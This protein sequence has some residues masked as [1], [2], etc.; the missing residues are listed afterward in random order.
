MAIRKK[1]DWAL[2]DS[3]AT[4]ENKFNDRRRLLKAM[5]VGSI[6]LAAPTVARWGEP[7]VAPP[8]P[9]APELAAEQAALYPVAR[10]P[11]Y[12]IERPLTDEE[13][14]TTYNNFYHFGSHKRI[15]RAAQALPISPW[16]VTIDGM[17]EKPITIDAHDLIKRMPLEERLYRH[18]CVEA[19]A[20][21]VPWSGFPLSALVSLAKPLSSARYLRME[22]FND[23]AVASGQKAAW[24]PWPYVEG[25]SLAEATN[26]LVFIATGIY[27]KPLPPQNGAPLRLVAPWKYGFKSIKSIKRITFTD[28][29]PV[30]FWEEL[31]VREYGFWANVNPA[32][33]HPRWSQARERVL[34]TDETIPTVLFNGYGAEVAHLYDGLEA[35]FG[36]RVWR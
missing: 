6:I 20:M 21:T 13:Y 9:V 2:P 15:W 30:S 19:W 31:A 5:A 18:R 27:G 35:E 34:G 36:D 8:P 12:T 28:V 17:V 1:P 33:D 25:L 7:S 16:Q 26:E 10:N 4:P 32:V 24:Y 14:A 3:A 22:T 23:P 11:R 29:R